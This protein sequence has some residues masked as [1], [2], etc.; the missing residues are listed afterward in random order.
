MKL[1]PQERLE[2]GHRIMDKRLELGVSRVAVSFQMNKGEHW[3]IYI[4]RGVNKSINAE[5]EQEIIAAIER[6][7]VAKYGRKA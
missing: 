7:R 4:E 1:T 2:I 6:A 3:L 5:L